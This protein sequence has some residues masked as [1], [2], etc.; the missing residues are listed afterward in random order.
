[1]AWIFIRKLNP[2]NEAGME[3]PNRNKKEMKGDI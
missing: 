2:L 1:M 3:I